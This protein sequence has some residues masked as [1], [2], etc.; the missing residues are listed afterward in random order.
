VLAL[1]TDGLDRKIS[2]VEL[3]LNILK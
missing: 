2:I 3:H 1:N